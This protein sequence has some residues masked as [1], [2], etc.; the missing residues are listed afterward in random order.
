MKMK[1]I[2]LG[3]VALF[4][5]FSAM[6]ANAQETRNLN[7][8]AEVLEACVIDSPATIDLAFGQ[9]DAVLGSDGAGAD[10]VVPA[11]FDF[12]CTAGTVVDIELGLGNGAGASLATRVMQGAG[13]NTLAYRLETTG[14]ADWGTI[15]Q[16]ASVQMT[17]TGWG[18]VDTATI[19]GRVTTAQA[20]AAAV[21][22]TYQDTVL[23]TLTL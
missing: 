21:D 15:A 3:A 13:T 23:I 18:T 20:A 8:T 12:H 2:L 1:Q 17:A 4:A 7:V 5:M 19:Q 16:V 9:L 14:T 10:W 11:D 22:A 6:E